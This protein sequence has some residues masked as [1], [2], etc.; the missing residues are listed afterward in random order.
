MGIKSIPCQ[1]WLQHP[2]FIGKKAEEIENRCVRVPVRILP[3]PLIV[4]FPEP[5]GIFPGSQNRQRVAQDQ[6]RLLP[7][8]EGMNMPDPRSHPFEQLLFRLL[9]LESLVP[10]IDETEFEEKCV[11]PLPPHLPAQGCKCL[12]PVG[13]TS[14]AGIRWDDPDVFEAVSILRILFVGDRPREKDT[15]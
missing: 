5:L 2:R 6:A 12:P 10:E 8:R 13:G 9:V 7:P 3:D 4:F 15:L 1:I 11:V 14:L